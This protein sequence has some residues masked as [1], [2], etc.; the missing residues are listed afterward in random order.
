MIGETPS[1]GPPGNP[2]NLPEFPGFNPNPYNIPGV[3][4][5]RPPRGGAAPV[6]VVPMPA[7]KTGL[8]ALEPAAWESACRPCLASSR[9]QA[10]SAEVEQAAKTRGLLIGGAVGVVFGAVLALVLR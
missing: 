6:P 2:F 3:P 1:P 5:Y 8:D 4:G 10:L 7:A 9:G